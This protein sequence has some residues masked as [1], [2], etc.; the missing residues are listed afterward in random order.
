MTKVALADKF[1]QFDEAWS[2]KI[3]GRV[4]DYDVKIA[5]IRGAFVW[6]AHEDADELFLVIAG[7]LRLEFRDRTEIVGPGEFVI[8]P[9]GVEHRPMSETPET[10]ILLF[11]RAGVVN[12]GDQA[13]SAHT[14]AAEDITG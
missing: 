1:A 4:D 14:N 13:P 5:K 8:A 10:Q 12:T 11:E 7:R 2:P 9:K 6:H 3:V